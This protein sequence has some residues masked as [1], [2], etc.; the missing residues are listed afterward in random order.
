M[1]WDPPDVMMDEP[2][3]IRSVPGGESPT[4]LD[5]YFDVPGKPRYAR[6]EEARWAEPACATGAPV[7]Y[8]SVGILARRS[9]RI[10]IRFA[11]GPNR[12]SR[13][14]ELEEAWAARGP[15]LLSAPLC[16]DEFYVVF[17]PVQGGLEYEP[18]AGARLVTVG[19]KEVPAVPSTP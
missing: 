11:W 10:Q 3:R 5:L 16:P 9:F 14:A 19:I 17:D 8:A 18:D 13:I 7:L 4:V 1:A 15:Y 12:N 2:W 6:P